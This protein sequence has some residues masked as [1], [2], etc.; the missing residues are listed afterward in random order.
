MPYSVFFFFFFFFF[1]ISAT[2]LVQ[3]WLSQQFSS[4]EGSPEFVAAIS[5]VSSFAGRF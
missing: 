1:L 3:S 4:I 2:T 5:G